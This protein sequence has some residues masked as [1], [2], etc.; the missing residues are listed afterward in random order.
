MKGIVFTTLG[1]MV[2]EKF[3]MEAWNALIEK[4]NPPNGGAYTAAEY[5]PD[6]ELLDFVAAASEM[7]EIPVPALVEAYGQY[8]FGTFVKKYPV[9]F[10]GQTDAKEFLKSVDGY[11]HVEVRKL[12]KRTTLPE[13][14]Y[15]DEA[16]NEL[17]MLYRS[18]RKMCHLSVGLIK[19]TSEHFN[20]PIE[21]AH[22]KCMHNGDDHCRL[23]LTFGEKA[24]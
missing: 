8:L 21:I 22:P 20:T 7:T 1:S 23:E 9:F 12:Y 10:E 5:Y 16:E 6:A 19:G 15:R 18:P 17:V 24:A 4:V 14:Q 2:E 13:F 11:I 3:G